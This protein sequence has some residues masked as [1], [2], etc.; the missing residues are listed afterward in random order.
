[1]HQTQPRESLVNGQTKKGFPFNFSVHFPLITYK[2]EPLMN[3]LTNPIDLEP[4]DYAFAN[5]PLSETLVSNGIAQTYKVKPLTL[6][7]HIAYLIMMINTYSLRHTE[8]SRL[9]IM[10]LLPCYTVN[11][12]LLNN[13]FNLENLLPMDRAHSLRQVTLAESRSIVLHARPKVFSLLYLWGITP[14]QLEQEITAIEA[15]FKELLMRRPDVLRDSIL[16]YEIEF[17]PFLNSL[18]YKKDRILVCYS[19]YY[20]RRISQTYFLSDGANLVQLLPSNDGL[21]TA[22]LNEHMKSPTKIKKPSIEKK[23]P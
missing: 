15:A 7:N 22:I 18:S 9:Q 16:N 11:L 14:K 12:G 6:V 4:I 13:L 23:E 17:V 21:L 19:L 10:T 3:I 20:L 5:I 1:M 2:E 8:I